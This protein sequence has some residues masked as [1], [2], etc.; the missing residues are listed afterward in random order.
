[1]LDCVAMRSIP[2]RLWWMAILSGLLQILPFPIAGPVPV[3][4]TAF[5]W[6]ALTPL[7]KALI[8]KDAS[9]QPIGVLQGT[10]LGYSAGV[11]WY[12]GNCYWIY[13][14]MHAY[15]G[16]AKPVAAG[17]LL[18]FCLYLGLYHAV[19]G[20]LVAVFRRVGW[21]GRKEHWR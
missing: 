17:I 20:A 1:M 6:I 13:P 7:L 8:G 10:M 19:F 2:A 14:T 21:F 12:L 9:D 3:W 15:G 5:C 18:L 16:L 4:R 11:V